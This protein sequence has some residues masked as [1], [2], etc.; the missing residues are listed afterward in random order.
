M[1]LVKVWAKG[2]LP[3]PPLWAWNIRFKAKIFQGEHYLSLSPFI[4]E[5]KL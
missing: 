2:V 5:L 1:P 3:M 4:P